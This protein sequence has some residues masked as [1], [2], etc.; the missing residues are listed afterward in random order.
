MKNIYHKRYL[1][2]LF[3]SLQILKYFEN[4]E[5]NVSIIAK[6]F[7]YIRGNR[8]KFSERGIKSNVKIETENMLIML[9]QEKFYRQN[10]DK[11]MKP[12]KKMDIFIRKILELNLCPSQQYPTKTILAMEV[13]RH[14]HKDS[15][16]L[17]YPNNDDLM[18]VCNEI[19]WNY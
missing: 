18:N 17:K 10:H 5:N 11:F 13:V 16:F 2:Q 3:V 4:N 6:D 15:S 12:R 8:F 7:K 14:L 9:F 19:I 1:R